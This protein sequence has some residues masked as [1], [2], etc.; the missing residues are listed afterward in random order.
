LGKIHHKETELS[1]LESKLKKDSTRTA[2]LIKQAQ[3]RE[4]T[5][6]TLFTRAKALEDE[7][8]RMDSIEEL[9]QRLQQHYQ[10][11]I[12]DKTKFSEI[13][14]EINNM[15]REIKE[16]EN[17]NAELT[18]GFSHKREELSKLNGEIEI[19]VSQEQRLNDDYEQTKNKLS[20]LNSSILE[21]TQFINNAPEQIQSLEK[22]EEGCALRIKE[23]ERKITVIS[24]RV[25]KAQMARM[26]LE[27]NLTDKT[28]EL[29]QIL[30]SAKIVK[31]KEKNIPKVQELSQ[32]LI[33]LIEEV[34]AVAHV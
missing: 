8:K 23:L 30:V 10:R 31:Q 28:K 22:E 34:Q 29:N 20:T 15:V 2:T 32:Q 4:K 33:T 13:E 25:E 9:S 12:E 3:E 21:K 5:A 11:A 26:K 16:I 7:M 17:R 24:K 18:A 27:E 14:N 6:G 19:L 1:G